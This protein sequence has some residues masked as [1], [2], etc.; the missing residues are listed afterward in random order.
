MAKGLSGDSRVLKPCCSSTKTYS[1][2]Q[3][4]FTL[5]RTIFKDNQTHEWKQWSSKKHKFWPT[6]TIGEWQEW[7]A[8]LEVYHNE[9]WK[10]LEIHN[11]IQLTCHVP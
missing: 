10:R 7:V 6:F 9:T 3:P 11:F 8:R 2:A 4:V 1:S 5:A